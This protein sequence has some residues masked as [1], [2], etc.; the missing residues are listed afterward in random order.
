MDG[1]TLTTF[2]GQ[3]HSRA[4]SRDQLISHKYIHVKALPGGTSSPFFLKI[5]LGGVPL[6]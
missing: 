3:A 6:T 5:L 4:V 2:P 1:L